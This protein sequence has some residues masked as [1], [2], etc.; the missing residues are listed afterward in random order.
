[1]NR[2]LGDDE[3]REQRKERVFSFFRGD[4]FLSFLRFSS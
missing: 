2:V 4:F 1:M 3:E